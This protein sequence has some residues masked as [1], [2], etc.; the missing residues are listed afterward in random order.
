MKRTSLWLGAI[1]GALTSLPVLA[2]MY[3]G[4]RLAGLPFL[5]FDLFDWIARVLPGE[6]ITFGI[7]LIVSVITILPLG[8]TSTAAKISEQI[9]AISMVI[10]MG[11]V[12]G[13]VVAYVARR[14]AEQTR[15]AGYIGAT[16]LWLFALFIDNQVGFSAAGFVPKLVWLAFLFVAWG[17]VLILAV[18]EAGPAFANEEGARF[19]RRD[20]LTTGSISLAAVTLGAWGL[21][22]FLRGGTATGPGVAAAPV[23]IGSGGTSGPAASPPE[24]VLAARPAPVKGTRSE[25]TPDGE[26]YRIDINTRALEINEADWK[27]EVMGLVDEPLNLTLEEIRAMPSQTQVLTMQCI[28]NR[29]GSDLTGTARW[30][31]VR[32]KQVMDMAGLQ[33]DAQYFVIR[34]GDDFFETVSMEDMLDERTLLVYDMNGAPLETKHGFPLRIYIPNRYGMKQPKWIES[35]EAVDSWVE[36]YWVVRGWSKE[37]RPRTVSVVD[38]VA[39]DMM[40]GG[41]DGSK[42]VEVGGMAWAGA[43]GIS[44]VEVQV[45]DGAWT[46]VDLISPALSPLTWVLW[47]YDW[48]FEEGRHVFKVRA[49][50]GAGEIQV[51][52]E[53]PPRPDGATGIHSMSVNV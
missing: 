21:G 43:R 9:M 3:L 13:L 30:T 12:F 2:L 38:T 28:S 51:V 35:I 17:W 46:E 48:P 26:F 52:E 29:I 45:D 47:R 18:N 42:T 11:A 44:K 7:D 39:V 34:S 53:N 31:G 22:R 49:Y 40:T 16:V 37:A 50:D 8:D 25:I 6:V 19:S 23:Q 32:F 33:S 14:N 27:L 1:L 5:P 36:G 4:E 15:T 41:E 24:E 10:A 20:F